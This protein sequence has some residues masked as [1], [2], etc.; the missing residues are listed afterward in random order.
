MNNFVSRGGVEFARLGEVRSLIPT[1]V[2]VMALTA[3]ATTRTMRVIF[4]RLCMDQ[5]AIVYL[6][7]TKKNIIIICKMK[8]TLIDAITPLVCHIRQGRKKAKRLLPSR[9]SKYS[10]VLP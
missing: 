2:K 10:K 3:T 9:C 6:P 7:P 1:N 5:V 8:G 4:K